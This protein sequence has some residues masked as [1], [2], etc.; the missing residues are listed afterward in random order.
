MC[1]QSRSKN[2]TADTRTADSSLSKNS[3]VNIL[4]TSVKYEDF[5]SGDLT[6]VSAEWNSDECTT[7]VVAPIPESNASNPC[8]FATSD[9]LTLY[10][11]LGVSRM[12]SSLVKEVDYTIE[13]AYNQNSGKQEIINATATVVITDVPFEWDAGQDVIVNQKFSVTYASADKQSPSFTAGNRNTRRRSGNPGYIY[14]KPVLYGYLDGSNDWIRE[15]QDGYAVASSLGSFDISTPSAFGSGQCPTSDFSAAP[16]IYNGLTKVEFGYDFTSGCTVSLTREEMVDFCC[17]GSDLC[18]ASSQSLYTSSN[19]IPYFFNVTSG[20][21]IG[22]YGNADPSDSNQWL[23]M[24]IVTPEPST[25]WSSV[26]STCFNMYTGLNVKFLVARTGEKLN[27]QNKIISALTEIT[28]SDIVF[29][30]NQLD[31]N[32]KY[33]ISLTVSVSFIFQEEGDIRGYA[34]P[35]RP[36]LFKVPYDVFYPF[37]TDTSTSG[38]A[39]SSIAARSSRGIIVACLLGVTV[40]LLL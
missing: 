11:E 17:T 39:S 35:A 36:I 10:S 9:T 13:Y 4:I 28:T 8:E 40:L 26:A 23:P 2:R 38:V 7:N 32:S 3:A 34:P 19:G 31:T 15:L 1:T 25:E 30:A 20:G 16:G 29:P 5:A 24:D 18:S 14:G 21:Y 37:Y 22:A 27:P 33:V 12:C 6:T